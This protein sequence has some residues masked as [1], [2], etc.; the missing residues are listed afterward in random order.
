M[1]FRAVSCTQLYASRG[2]S[3]PHLRF[4]ALLAHWDT[5][6]VAFYVHI[7]FCCRHLQPPTSPIPSLGVHREFY[8]GFFCGYDPPEFWKLIRRSQ[9]ARA[10]H[11]RESHGA[12]SEPSQCFLCT[13]S[14]E[15]VPLAFS[16]L[17]HKDDALAGIL[18]CP[19]QA[20]WN[21]VTRRPS[22]RVRALL[23]LRS[24]QCQI[25]RAHV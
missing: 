1:L 17:R 5:S 23:V 11:S 12:A 2:R 22:V 16:G 9:V 4:Q 14:H 18:G 10:C 8:Q 24:A 19:S 7:I 21:T 6:Q 3:I 20:V 25:G 15:R 13:R